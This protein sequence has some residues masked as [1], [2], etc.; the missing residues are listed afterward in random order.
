[1]NHWVSSALSGL[2]FGNVG[3]D[4]ILYFTKPT[5]D[6]GR[7]IH[8]P[9]VMFATPSISCLPNCLSS[10]LNGKE[11]QQ[12]GLTAIIEAVHGTIRHDACSTSL[13]HERECALP[14]SLVL[15][16]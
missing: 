2:M 5:A 6:H 12:C 16:E 9:T 10:S 4:S 13:F 8:D 3:H 11:C 1:M 7:I 15:R 14:L